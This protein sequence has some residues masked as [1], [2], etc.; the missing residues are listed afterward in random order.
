M[1][2]QPK[3]PMAW[4]IIRSGPYIEN[5]TQLMAPTL[6]TNGTY[7]FELPLGTGA[8][9]YIDLDDFARYVRWALENVE[10]SNGLDLGVA[11]VHASGADIANAFTATTGKP[12][13]YVDLPIETWNAKTW[14]KLPN[15]PDTKVGFLTVKDNNAL[16]QSYGENFANWWNL[17]K[18]SAGNKGL[19]RRDY[20]LL[21]RILPSRVKS[22]EEWMKKVAY[23]GERV[24]VLNILE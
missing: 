14:T 12:A 10:E 20:E 18:A 19:I 17:Y 21:D 11:T 22:V 1:H 4:S 23:S 7:H 5:L 9:P 2:A 16:L 3:S 15:G 13:K 8:I 6:S 24:S